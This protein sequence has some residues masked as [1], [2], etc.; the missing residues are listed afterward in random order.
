MGDVHDF[1]AQDLAVDF[2]AAE[3]PHYIPNMTSTFARA[4]NIA[5][6]GVGKCV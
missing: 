4:L 2:M 6:D 1:D 5:S 3:T